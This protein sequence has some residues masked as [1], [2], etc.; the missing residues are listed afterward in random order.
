L[1]SPITSLI[2]LALYPE[3]ERSHQLWGCTPHVA[4][5]SYL[6]FSRVSKPSCTFL[7]YGSFP[8]PSSSE[9]PFFCKHLPSMFPCFIWPSSCP[10]HTF[11]RFSIP[12]SRH[13]FILFSVSVRGSTRPRTCSFSPPPRGVSPETVSLSPFYR[14]FS[15]L[16]YCSV[17]F[18]A[19]FC[20]VPW[21]HSF[22]KRLLL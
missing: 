3:E 5:C 12:V 1:D 6:G 14:A 18:L 20:I 2:P 10:P 21:C 22:H 4:T 17:V 16:R 13:V 11:F 19:A 8:G 7:Y 9:W 15:H